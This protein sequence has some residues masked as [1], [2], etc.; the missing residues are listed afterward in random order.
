[1]TISRCWSRNMPPPPGFFSLVS[2]PVKTH[3]VSAQLAPLP[4]GHSSDQGGESNP[5]EEQPRVF[6]LGPHVVLDTL[7][8]HGAC[9]RDRLS[10]RHMAGVNTA[11]SIAM[12][13]PSWD[14]LGTMQEAGQRFP[15]AAY[16]TGCGEGTEV[17]ARFAVFYTREPV[18]CLLRFRQIGKVVAARRQAMGKNIEA[19]VPNLSETNASRDLPL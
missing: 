16:R 12:L 11:A 17:T 5:T 1:M 15:R 2:V 4:F 8:Y 18:S 10:R 9:C 13:K 6:S 14:T 19:M 3:G 7:H